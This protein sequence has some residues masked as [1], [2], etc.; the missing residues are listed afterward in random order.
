MLTH[1]Q[2]NLSACVWKISNSELLGVP[3]RSRLMSFHS[4]WLFLSPR[5]E[6]G[7]EICW[8]KK[9]PSVS[10]L[11]NQLC[12]VIFTRIELK[13]YRFL[14]GLIT[15]P[16]LWALGSRPDYRKYGKFSGWWIRML[17]CIVKNFGLGLSSKSM[18]AQT[19]TP[20]LCCLSEHT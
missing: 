12:K 4:D 14:T 8:M 9:F 3:T 16:I 15:V 7:L 6:V 17:M 20:G 5:V 11:P 1:K 13:C 10:Q 19:Q 18:S 2:D